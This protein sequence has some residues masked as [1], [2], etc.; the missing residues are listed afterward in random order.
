MPGMA[1]LPGWALPW[2]LVFCFLPTTGT[3]GTM[4]G[5]DGSPA[6]PSLGHDAGGAG[7]SGRSGWWLN[8]TAARCPG[9]SLSWPPTTG[10]VYHQGLFSEPV[11]VM[12]VDVG[13]ESMKIAI[14]KPG[15]PM[16]IVLNK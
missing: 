12:S 4:R 11:A 9:T 15:V 1:Q 16:E 13:S 2:L 3:C 10:A 8:V 7:P 6:S 14:V 5:L